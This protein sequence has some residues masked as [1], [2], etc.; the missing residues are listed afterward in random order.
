[1]TGEHQAVPSFG[2]KWSPNSGGWFMDEPGFPTF[3]SVG[4]LKSTAAAI[5]RPVRR[6]SLVRPLSG[7][8]RW[9][10]NRRQ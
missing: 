6:R 9:D 2:R 1:L 5:S 8:F 4:R 3:A 7:V 10:D